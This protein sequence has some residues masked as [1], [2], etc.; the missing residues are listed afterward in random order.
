[1]VGLVS[2]ADDEDMMRLHRYS[3]KGAAEIVAR[4]IKSGIS[5]NLQNKHG[6][7][8][9]HLACRNGHI[10][11]LRVLG[12]CPN[13]ASTLWHK[14]YPIHNAVLQG[15]V[16]LL[17]ELLCILGRAKDMSFVNQPDEA[18]TE[19]LGKMRW[20]TFSSA[21]TALHYA[22]AMDNRAVA[23]LLLDTGASLAARDRLGRTPLMYAAE[24]CSSELTQLLLQHRPGEQHVQIQDKTGATVL[25][26]ALRSDNKETV[27][28][29]VEAVLREPQDVFT[30]LTTTEDAKAESP[31]LMLVTS[32]R[33][34]VLKKLLPPLD[35]L[36][37]LQARFHD[38]KAILHERIAWPTA[39]STD[40]ITPSFTEYEEK[41]SA[42]I[43]LLQAK[44][45]E[46]L[47]H[48]ALSKPLP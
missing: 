2:K 34:D 44:L 41:K 17:R 22:V 8:A 48:R 13:L 35:P 29:I 30:V 36:A 39:R 11:V 42:T 6:C 47:Q 10:G 46:S 26:Y 5:P 27:D 12:H 45:D 23:Q 18:E 20:S 16:E 7:T 31:L 1:M 24:L 40:G 38:S 14:R 33:V 37:F 4:L 28:H 21:M 32:F 9:L 25:H 19:E 15:D 3:R 43:R